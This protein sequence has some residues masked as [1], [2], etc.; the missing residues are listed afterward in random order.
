MN[1]SYDLIVRNGMI[2]TAE[3][4]SR[5][6]IGVRAG[7]IAVLADNLQGQAAETIDAA[8]MLVLPGGIDSHCHIAQ[9]SSSGLITADDFYSGGISAAAG[10][11]T[12]MIPF[13]AQHRGQ[14]LAE[15]V[16]DYHGKAEGT[17]FIDYGFHL[18]ISDPTPAV[19]EKELPDLIQRGC[20]SVKIYTTYDA[21]K[22]TDRQILVV[23]EAAKRWGAMVMVHAENHDLIAWATE[24][25]LRAGQTASRFH[26]ASRPQV[27]ERE[28]THRVISLAELVDVPI[29]IVHVSG[30]EALE[31][32]AWARK[33]GR[34]VY[35]ET[36]P[37]YLVLSAD[38]PAKPGFEGTQPVFSPP[39]R[40][41]LDQEAL[42]EGLDTGVVEVFSS[43]HA[44][45]RLD[46]P[47]SKQA[48]GT[49]APF[50]KIPNGIPGLET[51]LPLLFSE[52]VCKGRIDL[53]TFAAITAAN[54]ARIYG[55]YPRKGTIA[56]GS[57]ADLAIWDPNL[58]VTIRRDRLHGRMDYTAFEGM[59]VQ[60]WPQITISRGEV[61]WVN[62]EIRGLPGRG[63]FLERSSPMS[64]LPGGVAL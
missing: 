37:Q 49:Q 6:D 7:K 39:A 64:C 62:G 30:R 59:K 8:G 44:P 61:V 23:L 57:D 33:R 42:W 31:Q 45:Y 22:L 2:V 63:L 3:A 52:G 46:D 38:D 29:L 16:H 32:I 47:Q 36:C 54:P 5:R 1:D 50:T 12:T 24:R 40:G 19:M 34:K 20:P 35:A 18:S 55:L 9:K 51:R 4:Q 11:T 17:A 48:H 53:C 10:G 58:E 27:A 43:D 13:A 28:A 15:A 25:L 21:L 14:S 56:V 60:G 41:K 26:P